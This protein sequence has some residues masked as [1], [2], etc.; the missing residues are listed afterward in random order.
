MFTAGY[1]QDAKQ[2]PLVSHNIHPDSLA[3][4][5]CYILSD[6]HCFHLLYLTHRKKK[7]ATWL[8]EGNK[9]N[10]K[11]MS[12]KVFKRNLRNLG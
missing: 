7:N 2:Q 4:T 6:S 11:H 5:D 9:K 8:C 1:K 3:E 12:F 10:P